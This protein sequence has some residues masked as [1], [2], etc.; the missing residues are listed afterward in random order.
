MGTPALVMETDT[1]Q[2]FMTVYDECSHT[3]V[4][5]R[6]WKLKE[7]ASA[8]ANLGSQESL[9]GGRQFWVGRICSGIQWV[10]K[11]VESM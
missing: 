11:G 5:L 6:L 2:V 7:E 8:L 1:E 3:G 10:G 9:L 4:C